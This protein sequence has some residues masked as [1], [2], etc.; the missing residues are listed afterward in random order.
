MSQ[1]S[2]REFTPEEMRDQL[3]D[4]IWSSIDYWDAEDRQP[5]ARGKLSGLAFSILC[6]LDGVGCQLEFGCDLVP[7]VHPGDKVEFISEGK[8]YYPSPTI[9]S[10]IVRLPG[11]LHE[12]LYA[13]RKS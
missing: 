1:P 13:K 2:P 6:L 4:A 10:D 12:H 8:N 5:T 11:Y 7:G 9:P 3:I